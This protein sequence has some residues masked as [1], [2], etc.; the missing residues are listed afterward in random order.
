MS[1]FFDSTYTVPLSHSDVLRWWHMALP[2][3]SPPRL[4]HYILS[5]SLIL[6]KIAK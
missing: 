4:E 3:H 1:M 5:L 6:A 2:Y